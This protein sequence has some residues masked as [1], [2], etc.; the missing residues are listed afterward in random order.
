VI[1][2]KNDAERAQAARARLLNGLLA[3]ER[4]AQLTFRAMALGFQKASA[5]ELAAA[6]R[7]YINANARVATLVPRATDT[8]VAYF[9]MIEQQ[10]REMHL[11]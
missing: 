5:A 3:I 7:A 8:L 10:R 6:K 1:E 9:A 11:G 4:D 2:P